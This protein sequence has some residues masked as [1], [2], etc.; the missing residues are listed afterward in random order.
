M[1]I[2]MPLDPKPVLQQV[3][4]EVVDVPVRHV[5]E[6]GQHSGTTCTE[7]GQHRAMRSEDAALF[8]PPTAAAKEQR[9]AASLT[10]RQDLIAVEE[11]LSRAMA[12]VNEQIGVQ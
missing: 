8:Q 9:G 4:A 12:A 7:V 5:P 11:F 1:M 2:R 3:H 10:K 6:H